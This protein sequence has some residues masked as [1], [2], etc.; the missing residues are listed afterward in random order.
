MSKA[1]FAGAATLLVCALAGCSGRESGANDS[2]ITVENEAAPRALGPAP[3]ESRGADFVA[4]VAAA[5]QF[6]IEA[7]QAQ[8]ARGDSADVKAVAR[9]VE[10]QMSGALA[11][12]RTAAGS[13][14]VTVAPR[15]TPSHS[16]DLAILSSTS[17]AN[18]DRVWIE[19]QMPFL[20]EMLGLVR[21]FKNSGDAPALKAWAEKHQ[22]TIDDRLIAVQNWR[23][24]LQGV[25]E[26]DLG[27]GDRKPGY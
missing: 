6:A 2:A 20:T 13:A 5:L 23:G 27:P 4:T 8:Q 25:A 15:P 14:G 21:S 1:R 10:T 18:L 11:D 12:L 19:Q 26:N 7:A 16:T 22:S 9:N 24:Y 3:E 17:G